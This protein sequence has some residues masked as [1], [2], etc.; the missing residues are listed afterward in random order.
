[1]VRTIREHEKAEALDRQDLQDRDSEHQ[2]RQ[3]RRQIE[4]ED[5]LHGEPLAVEPAPEEPATDPSTHGVILATV[6]SGDPETDLKCERVQDRGPN[7]CDD[8]G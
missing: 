8:E 1:M 7:P 2:R 6:P 3:R 5:T 4:E